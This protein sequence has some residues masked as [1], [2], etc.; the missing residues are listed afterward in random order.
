MKRV[1]QEE[2]E[3]LYKN[4][5]L[6][7]CA[8]SCSYYTSSV[9]NQGANGDPGLP[10]EAGEPGQTGL[11]GKPV[12]TRQLYSHIY[13]HSIVCVCTF[14]CAHDVCKSVHVLFTTHTHR[15]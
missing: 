11:P 13:M 9:T 7:F 15:A 6:F 8:R 12:C 5:H 14:L 1:N 10:G 3:N 4:D 2:L